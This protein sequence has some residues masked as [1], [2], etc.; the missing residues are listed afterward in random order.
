[1]GNLPQP[2]FG[3]EEQ[4][5]RRTGTTLAIT[6]PSRANMGQQHSGFVFANSSAH[7]HQDGAK[8][9]NSSFSNRNS[10]ALSSVRSGRVDGFQ[11]KLELEAQRSCPRQLERKFSLRRTRYQFGSIERKKRKKGPDVWVLRYY[12]RGA[13]GVVSYAS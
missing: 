12:V 1:V 10:L 13:D 2:N 9:R 5:V 4:R 8:W 3:L 6:R 11:G 7:S